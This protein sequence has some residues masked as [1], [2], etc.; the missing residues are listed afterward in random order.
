LNSN[1]YLFAKTRRSLAQFNSRMLIIFLLL[2]NIVIC[3]VLFIN[4]YN[5]QRMELFEIAKQEMNELKLDSDGYLNDRNNHMQV[6]GINKTKGIFLTY[7][8]KKDHNE[9][10]VIDEFSPRWRKPIINHI[11]NW[12]PSKMEVRYQKIQ[13]AGQDSLYLLIVSQNIY[14][15]GVRKGTIYI[16]KDISALRAMFLHFLLIL[17]GISFIFFII[18]LRGGQLMTRKAMQP[19]MKTY[20]LQSEFMADASHELRT[21]L[22]VLKSGLEVIEFEEGNHF[23]VFSKS[24]LADLKEEVESTTKLVNQL[25]LLGRS[26]SGEQIA[27]SEKVNLQELMSQILRSFQHLAERKGVRMTLETQKTV[28]VITDREKLKQL[29]YILIDNALKYTPGGGLVNISY[30][31]KITG[32]DHKL[33]I[34]VRDNGIGI[35]LK[36]QDRIFDRFYRVDKSRSRKEG[37][38]GLG[39]SIAKSIVESLQGS[40]IVLSKENKGSE[41]LISIPIKK[42]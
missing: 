24:I 22:S 38:Q 35:P 36:Q 19:I 7:F 37:S 9:L 11:K 8:L 23:S 41:F 27:Q 15:K 6:E 40:I 5:E 4:V 31:M 30:E 2:F 3:A 42:W 17:L 18:A 39:L 28:Q 13:L 10:G 1:E 14:E 25:L 21:P 32:H 16:G 26:D 33:M 29:L 12:H 34:S 20:T